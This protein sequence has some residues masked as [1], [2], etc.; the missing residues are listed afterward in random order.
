MLL[1]LDLLVGVQYFLYF[2]IL[3]SQILTLREHVAL[4]RCY[5]VL[6]VCS[7]LHRLLDLIFHN[8]L[9]VDPGLVYDFLPFLNLEY[10]LSQLFVLLAFEHFLGIVKGPTASRLDIWSSAFWLL[11]GSTPY[12][13]T[14]SVAWLRW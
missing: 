12:V 5:Q 8:F 3:L 7:L 1:Y 11:L 9:H 6:E 13:L 14:L 10:L 4:L 2:F